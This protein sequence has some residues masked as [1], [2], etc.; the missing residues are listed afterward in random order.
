MGEAAV[1]IIP[2]MKRRTVDAF[3]K[4]AVELDAPL[5]ETKVSPVSLVRI[6]KK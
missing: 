5:L 1:S 4:K 2:D 3:V 6:E